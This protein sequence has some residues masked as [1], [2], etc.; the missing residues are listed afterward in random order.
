M[1]PPS[2]PPTRPMIAA[3]TFGSTDKGCHRKGASASAVD[4][5]AGVE[6]SLPRA[7]RE[8]LDELP[9][10]SG[11]LA[12]NALRAEPD[13]LRPHDPLAV[14]SDDAVGAVERRSAD[15]RDPVAE[16]GARRACVQIPE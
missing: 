4:C 12:V 3:T 10:H 9:S 8:R 2:R 11:K 7:W 15:R 5:S 1:P 16:H 6:Q 14:D 13:G